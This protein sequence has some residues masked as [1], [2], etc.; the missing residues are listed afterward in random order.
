M[1]RRLLGHDAAF[2]GRALALVALDHVDAAHQRTAFGRTHLDHLTGATLIASGQ[3]DHLVALA[4]L[5]RHHSTSGASE[6]IFMWFLAR[7][8]RGTGPKMRLPTGS[9]CGVIRTAALRSNRMIEPSGRRMSLAMRTTTA[10]IT[11]PFLTRPRG[12]A[13][14][15]ETTMTSPT[16]AYLRLEPPSTLMHMTRRA[17]E[18]SATSRLVCIWIMMLLSFL[19]LFGRT[20]RSDGLLLLAPDRGPALEP[21]DRPVFLDPHRVA[22]V[23]FVLLVV[24]VVLL[25][26]ANRLLHLRMREAALDADDDGLVL[27]V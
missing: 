9:I 4:N 1:D 6:M 13:S 27:L 12:I 3:H 11:S 16:V 24:G 25:R 2:L 20:M 14:L 8:S 7:S 15:T 18:L 19:Y 21:R 23:E 22:D 17:P 5:R 26:A 10:F